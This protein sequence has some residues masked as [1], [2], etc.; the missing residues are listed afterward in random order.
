MSQALVTG[1]SG[2]VGSH[3]LLSL[4]EIA[5]LLKKEMGSDAKKTA[6]SLVQLGLLKKDYHCPRAF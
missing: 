1:G 2:F 4:P 3:C 6:K 5:K